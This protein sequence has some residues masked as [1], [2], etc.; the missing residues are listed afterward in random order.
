MPH[1]QFG[2][3]GWLLGG[4]GCAEGLPQAVQI[5]EF[6]N[7]GIRPD[8]IVAYSVGAFNGLD[9]EHALSIWE[10]N[11]SS[12]WDIY[13]LN[14]D[15]QQLITKVLKVLPPPLLRKHKSKLELLS[16]WSK[17]RKTRYKSM[18]EFW[19]DLRQLKAYLQHILGSLAA[20]SV[21][22]EI[23]PKDLTPLLTIVIEEAKNLGINKFESFFDPAPLTKTLQKV[24]DFKKVLERESTYNILTRSWSVDHIFSC[25]PSLSAESAEKIS[26]K[27]ILHDIRSED[28]VMLAAMA[29]SAIRPFFAPVRFNGG[30]FWDSGPVNPFPVGRAYDAGCD[31]VFA[32][33]RNYKLSNQ[34]ELDIMSSFTEGDDEAA[35]RIFSY[36]SDRVKERV[37]RD[38]KKLPFIIYPQP[39]HPDLDLLWISPQ[40]MEYTIR[41]ETEATKK[42][43]KE[44]LNIDPA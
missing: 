43:L 10:N 44:N 13:D 4:G 5:R 37:G 1:P 32:F 11:F 19:M 27:Y 25:G 3:V 23:S 9:P 26:L 24:L 14:H 21:S 16:D 20:L 12:P 22:S 40:A 36:Q 28:Q 17:Y 38:G 15:I 6:W 30:I 8:Y 18:K 31:T 39:L 34:G 2:R 29:S 7:A 41:V 35:R 33:V 42:W